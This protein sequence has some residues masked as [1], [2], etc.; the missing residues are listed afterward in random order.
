MA[1]DAC[2]PLPVIVYA[3]RNI[4]L[5]SPPSLNFIPSLLRLL[6]HLESVRTYTVEKLRDILRLDEVLASQED[7]AVR[8]LAD[9]D[10]QALETLTKPG[11]IA[12]QRTVYRKIVDSCCLLVGIYASH[13]CAD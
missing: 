11:R 4:L 13:R 5:L 10:R 12:A 1:P 3:I 6:A 9:E 8:T 2:P 7:C